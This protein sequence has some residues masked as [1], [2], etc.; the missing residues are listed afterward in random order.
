MFPPPLLAAGRVALRDEPT[1]T[2]S[3]AEHP[4]GGPGGTDAEVVLNCATASA[5]SEAMDRNQ[6]HDALSKLLPGAL[7]TVIFKSGIPRSQLPGR[8]APPASRITHLLEWAEEHGRL[9]DV[10]Q[11]WLQVGGRPMQPKASPPVVA[12]AAAPPAAAVVAAPAVAVAAAFPAA[13]VVAPP[14]VAPAPFVFPPPLIDAYRNDRLAILFGSGLSLAR[15]VIGGF[16]RWN[17]LSDRLLDQAVQQGVWSQAQIDAKRAFFKAGYVSLEAMLVELDTIKT[18]LQSTRKYRAALTALFRPVNATPGDVHRA[19]VEVDA[20]VLVTTNYDGLLELVGNRRGQGVYTWQKADQALDDIQGNL[21]VLFKIHGTAE[22]DD[23]V[24]MTRTE[25]D[26]AATHEPYRRVMSLLLQEYTF[27]LVGYGINDPL[28]LDLVFELNTK[29]FGS[30]ARTH[31]ALMKDASASDRDRWQ[32]D[33]NVQVLP[34]QD[35]D[36]L[37]AILRELRATKP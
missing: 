36:A 15:D 2:A 19:L 16:P 13:N 9:E 31:Y 37:P 8:E 4:L 34:Y 32:R 29:A 17:D 23:S 1:R 35:H 26:R 10:E 28:D 18:A 14:A 12:L 22:D 20:K 21:K 27:I 24:I 11:I 7:D 3:V 6:L 33:L 5:N 25:Y 30:A